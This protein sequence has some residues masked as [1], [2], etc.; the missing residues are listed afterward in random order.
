MLENLPADCCEVFHYLPGH[1]ETSFGNWLADQARVFQSMATD[2]C[3]MPHGGLND[4]LDAYHTLASD[5]GG[6][7][8]VI[9]V[10]TVCELM[11]IKNFLMG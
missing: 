1:N 8:S 6:Y 4:C 3:P 11:I 9:C 5:C 2:G 10:M 7:W